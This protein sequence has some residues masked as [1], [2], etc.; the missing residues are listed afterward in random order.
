MGFFHFYEANSVESAFRRY[1]VSTP[2][3]G[4]LSF[5]RKANSLL[6][7]CK[8]D[9]SMP[10]N[11]LLSFLP[12]LAIS[13]EDKNSITCQCPSTGFFHFYKKQKNIGVGLFDCVNA[14][15]RASFISTLQEKGGVQ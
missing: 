1:N 12:R 5:L 7:N 15:Q 9:V 11:G 4:L 10:F 13:D 8:K 2:F 6:K 14:L 3:I